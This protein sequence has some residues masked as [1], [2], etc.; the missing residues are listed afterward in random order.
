VRRL[1]NSGPVAS[2]GRPTSDE[3]SLL[4][5][6]SGRALSMAPP[7]GGV[8]PNSSARLHGEIGSS[9]L[10]RHKARSPSLVAVATV[11]AR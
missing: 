10:H 6:I 2:H 5:R 3:G 11:T 4:T 8:A 7:P 9:A 1:R